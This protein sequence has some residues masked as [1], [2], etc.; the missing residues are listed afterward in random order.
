MYVNSLVWT[1]HY[2]KSTR[3]SVMKTGMKTLLHQHLTKLL[4]PKVAAT[5]SYF[6]SWKLYIMKLKIQT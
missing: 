6:T 4:P 5:Y 2:K 3:E 1:E